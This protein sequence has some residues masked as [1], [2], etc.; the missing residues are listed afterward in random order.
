MFR[1]TMN[2][3]YRKWMAALLLVASLAMPGVALGEEVGQSQLEGA[4]PVDAIVVSNDPVAGEGAVLPGDSEIT[5]GPAVN[6][7][8]VTVTNELEP[9][10]PAS[11]V[12][13]PSDVA[14]PTE[15]MG[16]DTQDKTVEGTEPTTD[17]DTQGIETGKEPAE[18]DATSNGSATDADETLTD[19]T[20][21]DGAAAAEPAVETSDIDPTTGN[22]PDLSDAESD[23][24]SGSSTPNATSDVTLSA[25][26]KE[27]TPLPENAVDVKEGTY[28][29]ETNVS[30]EKVLDAAGSKPKIGSNVTSYTYHGGANQRWIVRKDAASSWYRIYS[31]AG[32]LKLALSLAA[33]KDSAG[34]VAV[35]DP[36]TAGDAAL[37]AFVKT[38]TWYN[39]VNRALPNLFLS[40]YLGG[41]ENNTNVILAKK[42]AVPKRQRFYLIDTKV[43]V[44]PDA[45]AE[46]GAYNVSPKANKNVVAEVRGANKT[47]GANVWLYAASGKEHQKLYLERE[48]D[49]FYTIWV[50][51]TSKVLATATTS[52]LPGNNVVQRTRKANAPSQKW[53]LRKNSDGTYTFINKCTGL[54]LG[55]TSARKGGNLVGTRN[56]G[57]TGTR[58]RLKRTAL[59]NAGIVEIHPRLA[60]KMNLHVRG[61]VSSGTAGLIL[62]PDKNFHNQRFELVK[63]GGT[64]LWRI[65][66]ASSGGW[67]TDTGSEVRQQGKGAT[68]VTK[69]N[70]WRVTF[71]GGGYC[72]VNRSTGRALD[73]RRGKT[74]NATPIVSSKPT[75]SNSQHF[76]FTKANLLNSGC[77]FLRSGKGGY[78]DI[79]GDSSGEGAIAQ[80]RSKDSYLGQYFTVEQAGLNIR[81]RNT[82]SDRYLKVNGSRKV[83]QGSRK[84]A[85]AQL[86]TARI[87]DGG[88]VSLV[89]VSTKKTLDVSNANAARVASATH[90]TAQAW[91][92]EATK[93]KPFSGYL[94]RAVNKANASHSST[95][96]LLV[97]DKSAHKVIAMT[98][99]NGYWRPSRIMSCSVG[100]WNTPT[101]EGSFTVGSRGTSF[102][103]GYT[104]W[105]W[106]Q[107]YADYLF[108][109]V[110]YNPG[111][112]S[113]VQDGR[114]GM[115]ISHG[116]VRMPIGDA[117][118][119][120]SSVPSGTRV[121][122]YS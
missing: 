82:Y 21:A 8:T 45:T 4:Q 79:K 61:G 50:V 99:G 48:S 102:G 85:E 72:L 29:I 66:T 52:I 68:A 116:C 121:L 65:R 2:D 108:H 26:D 63:A 32:D 5:H 100:A 92:L 77:Y 42:S 60:S 90:T 120:Y 107:F 34:N 74:V 16:E 118:W 70:T 69:T 71:K 73:L 20:K 40:V 31:A 96:H 67:V 56:D 15:T 83:V 43:D 106:T 3:S 30:D 97:V 7:D 35:V 104:C 14:A 12:V 87:E 25:Q 59:L 75:G 44:T 110:L 10:E 86:W 28:V 37:W 33:N 49:G 17:T 119:I 105:Y 117:H 39:L 13:A 18:G 46:E 36:E 103:Y 62:W 41:T 111:S 89:N 24:T 57:Y 109:S 54:A 47:S 93:Y 114:L 53:A 38:D 112:Q 84:K 88:R 78:L 94:L 19:G 101:V 115:H 27:P 55:A 98:G 81:I 58:F 6:P 1:Q 113:S 51:G 91:K 122:I 23:I 76:I 95:G 80:L 64:D 11:G 9:T 22:S